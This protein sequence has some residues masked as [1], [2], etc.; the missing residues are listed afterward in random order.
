MALAALDA[1]VTVLGSDGERRFGLTDLY[2]RPGDSPEIDTTL[3]QGDLITGVEMKDGERFAPRSTYLKVRDRASFEFAVVSV[4]AALR[5]DG[6]LIVEARLAIGGV[7][8]MPWR[9]TECES[10]WWNGRQTQK[11]SLRLLRWP[12][13][14]PNRWHKMASRSNC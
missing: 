8:P 1:Q 3:A 13:G 4:A 10:Y 11:A 12:S 9:L 2:R 7:A 5:L 14:T 6:G